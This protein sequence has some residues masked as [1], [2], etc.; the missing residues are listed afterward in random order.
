MTPLELKT[1]TEK[2]KHSN[3]MERARLRSCFYLDVK[4]LVNHP[5]FI[6]SGEAAIYVKNRYQYKNFS[7]SIHLKQSSWSLRAKVVL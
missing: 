7:K 6:G 5:E 3:L 1:V 4:E 2:I